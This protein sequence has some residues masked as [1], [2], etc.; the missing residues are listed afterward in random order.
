MSQT[1]AQLISDLVQALNFTGTSSAPANGMYLSAAN[2]ISLSTNSGPR[3][4]I[5]SVGRL[6]IGHSST[7]P[8]GSTASA[9]TQVHGTANALLSSFVGYSDNSGGAVLALGKSRGAVGT[10]G[11][12]VQNNDTLGVIRFAGDDGTDIQTQAALFECKVDGTVASNQIPAELLLKTAASNGTMTTALTISSSQNA[13]FAGT[14]TATTFIGALTGTA[15]NASGATG[16]FSIADKIVHTGDT[17]TAIRF[18]SQDHISVE[19]SGSEV[20]RIDSSGRILI[21]VNSSISGVG[22]QIVNTYNQFYGVGDNANSTVI[23]LLKTRNASPSGYTVLQDGDVIGE[24]RFRGSASDQYV[25]GAMIKAV[26]HGTPGAG[27]DLPTDIQFHTMPDGVGSTNERM[28]IQGD[29]RVLI[30]VTSD[31]GISSNSPLTIQNSTGSS[32]TRLNFVNSGSAH[33]ESTQIYSQNQDLVFVAGGSDKLRIKSDGKVGIGVSPIRILDVLAADGVTQA[34]LEKNSGS[35]NDTYVSALT[36]SAESSGAAAANYGPALGFQ[37]CFGASNYAGCLIASQCNSDTNTADL[38]F[39]PR[40]YGYTEAFRIKFNGDV[41]VRDTNTA[42]FNLH[43]EDAAITNNEVLGQIGF[44]GRDS[45]GIGTERVGALMKG[46][47]AATWDTGQAT[48]YTATNIDFFVQNNTG[49]DTIAAGYCT[50]IHNSGELI[51]KGASDLLPSPAA[52]FQINGGLID[53]EDDTSITMTSCANTGAIVDVGSFRRDG[54]SVTYANALFYVTYGSSTVVKLADPR[55]IFDVA[56]TDGKV[57]VFKSSSA[58][59]TFTI[60]NR[61]NTANKISVSVIRTMGL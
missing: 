46:V 22:L 60:K 19:T 32:A 20:L 53:I 50:R 27:N 56:D 1:K 31:S 54:G 61:M 47:A 14:C 52:S 8:V 39:Y 36:L 41:Q 10:P 58:S 51:Q 7:I 29:G 4:T 26:I 11:T 38:R 43:R 24:L 37:H 55:N 13:T 35:T 57:C 6:L 33:A 40:N 42:V 3:L 59:G 18:P 12:T 25:N 17:N 45:A 16:D 34:Y 28:R 30:G 44:T 15:S 23:D 2:T 9:L 49:T 48:G 21:G 5:D